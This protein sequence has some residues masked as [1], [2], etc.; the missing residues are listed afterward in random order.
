MYVGFVLSLF[1]GQINH[2][3]CA[4]SPVFEV[5]FVVNGRLIDRF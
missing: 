2:V 3:S 5:E 1:N 4:V